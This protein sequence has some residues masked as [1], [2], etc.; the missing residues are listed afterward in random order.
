MNR[1]FIAN[2]NKILARLAP[3]GVEVVAATKTRPIEEI[4]ELIETTDIKVAGENRV[5]ELMSKYDARYT[6]DFIGQL[7]TNKVKYIIDKV[8][9]IHSVDRLSLLQ[10]IEKEAEKRNITANILIEVNTAKEEN[11]GGLYLE[12]ALDFS[13]EIRN[14]PSVKLLG[15]MAVA[16]LYYEKDELEKCFNEAYKV[17][18]E[19]KT[20]FP[21]AK[22][23]SMGMSNDYRIAVDCGANLV[24]LGRAIFGERIV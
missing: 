13:Q 6:W 14:Y 18:T 22:Y 11:K 21:E 3:Y 16:P 1:D 8:R 5:Q 15:L 23:L 19:L 17:Y 2:A 10:T 9:L 24:R 20:G 12:D 7:Q 4:S